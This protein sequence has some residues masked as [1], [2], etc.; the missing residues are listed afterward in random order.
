M[1]YKIQDLRPN[2]VFI[3]LYDLELEIGLLTLHKTNLIL[4]TIGDINNINEILKNNPL[5]LFD[6]IWILLVNKSDFK[7]KKEFKNAIFSIAKTSEV[8]A[9]LKDSLFEVMRRSTPKMK[10]TK[11]YDE[12][13]KLNEL[14][15]NAKVCY[16]VY[17]DRLAKRYGYT[18]DQFYELTVAQLNILLMVS[19]DESY[20]DIEIQA[21]LQ[22][23]KLKAKMQYDDV[24]EKTDAEL[25]KEADEMLKRLQAEYKSKQGKK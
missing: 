7:N 8:S 17:Y 6:V 15:G 12:L 13:L 18:L 16:G 9:R 24:D 2:N 22:G 21:A 3:E 14:Q 19:S 11:K 25:D 20:H 5:L 23:K 1:E 4:E 10:N